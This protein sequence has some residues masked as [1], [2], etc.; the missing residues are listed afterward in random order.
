MVGFDGGDLASAL[1][2]TTVSQRLRESGRAAVHLLL[3][4][5]EGGSVT[6]ASMRLPVV[7]VNGAT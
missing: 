3:Q 5:L 1:S 6:T 4:A 7:L 2:L